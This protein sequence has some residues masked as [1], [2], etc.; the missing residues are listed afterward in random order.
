MKGALQT[1]QSASRFYIPARTEENRWLDKVTK[2][3]DIPCPSV[4]DAHVFCYLTGLSHVAYFSVTQ[5][6]QVLY[7]D[8]TNIRLKVRENIPG[9]LRSPDVLF[10]IDSP[11]DRT[12][13]HLIHA[14]EK[15]I[16][17]LVIM[18]VMLV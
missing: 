18:P 4:M 17:A 8:N 14:S 11:F 13:I 9:K 12:K 7:C 2:S 16:S 6:Q 10:Q 5:V 15:T 3:C 1:Y